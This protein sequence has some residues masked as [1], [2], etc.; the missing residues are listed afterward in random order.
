M[1]NLD[2]A[3]E[4]LANYADGIPDDL[5]AAI[6]DHRCLALIGSGISRRCL[7]KSRRPLPAWQELLRNLA[8]WLASQG[9]L[10]EQDAREIHDLINRGELTMVGQELRERTPEGELPRF[11]ADV[12]DPDAI[13][14]ARVH[15][16]VT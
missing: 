10:G 1:D 2:A 6:S 8:S 3:R 12:F 5:L 9:L 4:V 14:P 13:V 7:A 11:I 15:D 16:L